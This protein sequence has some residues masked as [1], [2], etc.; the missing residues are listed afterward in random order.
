MLVGAPS[1]ISPERARGKPPGPPADLWSLGALLY[2]SVEGHPPYD[3]GSAII[4]SDG[5]DDGAGALSE[6]G[7]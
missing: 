2:A 1:Y 5:C 6:A 3:K 7:R 4:D